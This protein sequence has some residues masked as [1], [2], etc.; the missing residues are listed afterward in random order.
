MH[1]ENT[2]FT[3]IKQSS[4]DNSTGQYTYSESFL[5]LN[6]IIRIIIRIISIHTFLLQ[7][8]SQMFLDT[9][10][11]LLYNYHIPITY[12]CCHREIQTPPRRNQVLE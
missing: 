8:P 5:L 4:S 1:Y 12:N 3:S 9:A 10:N 11:Q 2:F 7:N 6:Y